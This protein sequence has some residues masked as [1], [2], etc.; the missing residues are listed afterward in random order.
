MNQESMPTIVKSVLSALILLFPVM[1]APAQNAPAPQLPQNVRINQVPALDRDALLLDSLD[2]YKVIRQISPQQL[3]SIQINVGENQTM[4]LGEVSRELFAD[5]EKI[6]ANFAKA[7]GAI[8]GGRAESSSDV[9]E[10]ED[11]FILTRTT[12]A[13]VLDPQALERVSPEFKD[14]A[15][16]SAKAKNQPLSSLDA[17]S[18]KGFE[19]FIKTELPTLPAGDPLR[20]AYESGGQE[21]LLHAVGE[22][23]GTLEI[24]DTFVVPKNPLPLVDGKLRMPTI[25]KGVLDF[26]Q[27][28]PLRGALLSDNA[29]L[30]LSSL[31]TGRVDRAT[32]IVPLVTR[33]PG[34]APETDAPEGPRASS[35]QGGEE[36]FT[37]EFL[38]GFTRGN[39][40]QWER[41]W[42]YPSG[43]FRIS[44]G[45]GY[46]IGLRIPI[47]VKGRF[48]PTRL[49][50]KS[51]NSDRPRNVGLRIQANTVDADAAFY[52]RVGL[53]AAKVFEGKETVLELKFYYGMKFRALWTDIIHIPKTEMGI[54][55]GKN[56]KPPFGNSG[57]GYDIHIPASATGTDFNLSAI[58]GRAQAGFRFNGKGSI[59]L[60]QSFLLG[61]QAIGNRRLTFTS[62]TPQNLGFELPANP[63]NV[64]GLQRQQYGFRLTDPSYAIDLTVTP[65][66][67]ASVTVGYSWVSHTFSTGWLPLNVF[68]INLGRIRLDTHT[69]T[70]S[71][72]SYT[73]GLKTF[74]QIR[75][76]E[77]VT[78]VENTTVGIGSLPPRDNRPKE[79]V[80][81]IGAKKPRPANSKYE[82][83]SIRCAQ[84]NKIVRAGIGKETLLGAVSD[85]TAGW[86][87][88]ELIKLGG[89]R[90]ALR[91]VQNGKYVRAG[92]TAQTLLAAVSDRISGWETFEMTEL[93]GGRFTLKSTQNGKYVRAGVGKDTLLA[94]VSDRVA[95]WETF[96]RE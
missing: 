26:K 11:S 34:T 52:R 48:G 33:R 13:V 56:F 73:D 42:S 49:D 15:K 16:D 59:N 25:K 74:E 53:P 96:I 29:E 22:G 72:Y 70:T 32:E 17:A 91:S 50:F 40:W 35:T 39:S 82:T 88:F 12:K 31:S 9:V 80:V 44:L 75:F 36:R 79:P 1:S 41:R 51:N 92:V 38:A 45:A 87:T 66:V 61:A 94:A 54:D 43:F 71:S 27:T 89:N 64:G 58:R 95:G 28:T 57:S 76:A 67:L 21:A 81:G 63:P 65:L 30:L 24:T 7:R 20:K 84:N 4:N 8:L 93:G 86:E 68:K 77:G 2:Q 5:N 55:E 62:S 46:G 10:T 3:R 23:K 83:I 6:E 60:N 18:R 69:G 85:R 14:F 78:P 90:V 19:E 47:E 37:A